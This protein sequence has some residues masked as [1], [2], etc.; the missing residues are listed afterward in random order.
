MAHS[1]YHKIFTPFILSPYTM[2]LLRGQ[3]KK[4]SSTIK[5][6]VILLCASLSSFIL[7]I[8]ASIDV[9]KKYLYNTVLNLSHRS[10]NSMSTSTV[11]EFRRCDSGR[12]KVI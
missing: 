11:L 2:A 7:S 8:L 1:L 3:R 10:R 9:S 4:V 6:K 12:N 5:S